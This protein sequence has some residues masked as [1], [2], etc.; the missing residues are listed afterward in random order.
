MT[1]AFLDR[2][3]HRCHIFEQHAA[4]FRSAS[5]TGTVS[6]S[7]AETNDGLWEANCVRMRGSA[8]LQS[9]NDIGS[10]RVCAVVFPSFF[11]TATHRRVS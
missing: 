11:L 7:A 2:L 5:A 3:T 9:R 1:V 6:T 8:C 10:A 4:T